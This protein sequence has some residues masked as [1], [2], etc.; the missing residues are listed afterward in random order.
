MDNID[1]L[2]D[3]AKLLQSVISFLYVTMSLFLM[4]IGYAILLGIPAYA[5]TVSLKSYKENQQQ[6]K[7]TTEAYI[8]SKAAVVSLI[9]MVLSTLIFTFVFRDIVGLDN[10]IEEIVRAVLK[11][12]KIF[13]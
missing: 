11:I 12:N 13:N 7:N 9:T 10:N 8:Y 3:I 5:F 4:V 1:S 6:D 2:V